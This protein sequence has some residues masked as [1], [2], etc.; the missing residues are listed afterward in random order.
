MKTLK[1]SLITIFL[2]AILFSCEQAPDN[3]YTLKVNITGTPDL[4]IF[5]KQYKDGEGWVTH[6]TA[7]TVNGLALFYRNH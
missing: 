4:K 6:D 2:A 3:Q 5:L 1:F 7:V